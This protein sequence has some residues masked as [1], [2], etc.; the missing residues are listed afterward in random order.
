MTTI[1]TNCGVLNTKK[2]P[3]NYEPCF[4]HECGERVGWINV[5]LNDVF[6]GLCDDC[7]AILS[8]EG[9]EDENKKL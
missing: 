5:E 6:Y 8:Q 3:S 2:L 9:D 1:L 7:A 4:C